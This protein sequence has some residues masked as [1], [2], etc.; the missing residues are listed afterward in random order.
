[1]FTKRIEYGGDEPQALMFR[2][3]LNSCYSSVA[4]YPPNDY[5]N[6]ILFKEICQIGFYLLIMFLFPLLVI[7]DIYLADLE[8]FK[9]FYFPL[10]I[11]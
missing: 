10:E 11:D 1:M 3:S 2:F 9:S 7:I 4:M 5:L 6:E 8:E